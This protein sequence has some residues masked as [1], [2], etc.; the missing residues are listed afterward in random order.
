MVFEPLVKFEWLVLVGNHFKW[1]PW[2]FYLSL[3]MLNDQKDLGFP[4]IRPK[5]AEKWANF[6]K[7]MVFELLIESEWLVLVGNHFKKLLLC[8][9][10]SLLMLNVKKGLV[11]LKL[12]QKRPK[13]GENLLKSW[14]LSLWSK[15]SDLFR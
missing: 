9:S 6:A 8:F 14:I 4:E 7:I 2:C 10:S 12:G 15:L 11:F 13:N 3:L 1:I 5:M